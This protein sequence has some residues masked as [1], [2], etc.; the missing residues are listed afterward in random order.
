M[1]SRNA[2]KEMSPI[3]ALRTS[4]CLFCL[5]SF[6]LPP[7]PYPSLL[8]AQT[9]PRLMSGSSPEER[10]VYLAVGLAGRGGLLS[11][12]EAP[13]WQVLAVQRWARPQSSWRAQNNGG[14][15]CPSEMHTEVYLPTVVRWK[16]SRDLPTEGSGTAF[17]VKPSLLPPG[18][19]RLAGA[20]HHWRHA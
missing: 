4:T 9:C 8:K 11:P 12:H 15:R 10:V 18:S 1:I 7:V 16:E 19:A 3:P 20:P 14:G 13:V 2:S 17:S 6:L 5:L